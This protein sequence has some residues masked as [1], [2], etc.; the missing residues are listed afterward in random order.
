MKNIYSNNRY[1]NDRYN[2]H[3]EKR[4]PKTLTAF[5]KFKLGI[6]DWDK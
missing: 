5:E 2:K 1:K 3:E 4:Q 6:K